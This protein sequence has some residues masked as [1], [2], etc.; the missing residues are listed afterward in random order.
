M[1]AFQLRPA[2]DP[3]S[4]PQLYL[5]HKIGRG[6]NTYTITGNSLAV[7]KMAWYTNQSYH[8]TVNCSILMQPTAPS[9]QW[10]V[11]AKQGKNLLLL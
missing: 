11:L 10:A 1:K 3:G 5:N 6:L 4:K 9:A 8:S 2:E 7:Y